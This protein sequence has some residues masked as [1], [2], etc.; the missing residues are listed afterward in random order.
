MYVV[1]DSNV[2]FWIYTIARGYSMLKKMKESYS[3][4]LLVSYSILNVLNAVFI[5]IISSYIFT[6]SLYGIIEANSND[7]LNQIVG[8]ANS[9]MMDVQNIGK[10][11]A[12]DSKFH[13]YCGIRNKDADATLILS[14]YLLPK[15]NTSLM[16]TNTN[17]H[18]KLYLN[19]DNIP[20][21]YY[22]PNPSE[23]IVNQFEF[24]KTSYDQGKFEIL[25]TDRIK[26]TGYYQSIMKNENYYV[27][28]QVE[29]DAR[30]SRISF[31]I[32]LID[33]TNLQDNGILRL[34]IPLDELF[35]ALDPQKLNS[36]MTV[37]VGDAVGNMIYKYNVSDDLDQSKYYIFSK[38]LDG[39]D[40]HVKLYVNK[41]TTA[42]DIGKVIRNSVT[43]SML[44]FVVTFLFGMIMRKHMYKNIKNVMVGIKNFQ[45]GDYDFRISADGNDEFS[46]I[47]KLLNNFAGS[48]SHLI[49][50][51]YEVMIQKQDLELQA[52]QAKVN[53]HFL[54]NIL[55]I[56]QRSAQAGKLEQIESV[57][58]KTA[59]FYRMALSKNVSN[60]TL[61]NEIDM[62]KAYVAL[63]NIIYKNTIFV[64]YDIEE[65]YASAR[66]PQFIIQPF[67]ENAIK[68]AMIDG[69]INIVIRASAQDGKLTIRVID[70]GIGM[71]E[72][73]VQSMFSYKKEGYGL[74]NVNERILLRYGDNA[75]G[76]TINS[77]YQE[78]TEVIITLPLETDDEM[79]EE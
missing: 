38:N 43:I 68:H 50:D 35:E 5:G 18:A 21:Y 59:H 48:L 10:S 39:T 28:K 12:F 13:Y 17:L 36:D 65:R 69:K 19:N 14:D 2:F 52:L 64:T 47:S 40:L 72:A 30:L 60:N 76:V 3:L 42:H 34:I 29:D 49:D 7:I 25:H 32:K 9:K 26:N 57:S 11:F 46:E 74:Y 24:A 31:F 37:T 66:I 41:S 79:Y 51:V 15:G 54:Y 77:K 27:W 53:P 23:N 55:S 4:R 8:N 61:T 62:V 73:T 75:Y 78:G 71:D 22:Q 1:G 44:A 20:E 6:S 70:D 45:N 67:V 33:Y 63:V 56:I 58:E 16:Q